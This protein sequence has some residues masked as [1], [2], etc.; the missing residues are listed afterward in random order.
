[1]RRLTY[2]QLVRL[3][4]LERDFG[5]GMYRWRH[6]ANVGWA[7]AR[8]I[9]GAD[10]L[11]DY[12]RRLENRLRDLEAAD[13]QRAADLPEAADD[14]TATGRSAVLPAE[15]RSV[16]ISIKWGGNRHG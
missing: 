4:T 8:N 1:M 2:S 15:K 10:S 7:A 14:Q 13:R 5:A 9:A 11:R 16:P 12:C 3:Q 6:P